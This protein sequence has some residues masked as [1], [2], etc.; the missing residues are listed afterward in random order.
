[1]QQYEARAVFSM[2][3]IGV[4]ALIGR[5]GK[6]CRKGMRAMDERYAKVGVAETEKPVATPIAIGAEDARLMLRAR[7]GLCTKRCKEPLA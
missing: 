7:C 3:D 1:V 2:F 4:T 5:G 6:T